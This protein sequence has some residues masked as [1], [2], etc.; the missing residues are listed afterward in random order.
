MP[1]SEDL[2]NKRFGKLTVLKKLD[3][4]EDGGVVWLCQCECGNKKEVTTANLKSKRVQSCGCYNSIYHKEKAFIDLTGEKFGRLTVIKES[5]VDK[6][7]ERVWECQCDCGNIT[8]VTTHSL[9]HG[10]TKSCGCLV[11]ENGKKI[12]E[13][14]SLDLTGQKYGRLTVIEKSDKKNIKNK[15]LWKCVCDCGNTEYVYAST[16]D[17]RRGHVLSCGCLA[18]SGENQIKQIL[19]ENDIQFVQQKTFQ[20]CIFEDTKYKAIFD[21]WVENKYIIEFDGKQHFYPV[22]FGGIKK[23]QAQLN[24]EKTKEHDSI[25]NKWCFDNNIPIIRIPY[26]HK[27]ITIEDLRLETSNFILK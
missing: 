25:K 23:E 5:Y 16:R 24:F 2:T 22:Q 17:L 10:V 7:R 8:Y 6:K 21:F 26:T 18:S 12:K 27:T 19:K 1:K 4:R 20:D 13:Q 15:E 14:R 11:K 3:K 9:M